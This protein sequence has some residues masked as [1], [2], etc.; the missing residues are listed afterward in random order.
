MNPESRTTI[1]FAGTA[2]GLLLLVLLTGSR[3]READVFTAQGKAFYPDFVD[4]LKATAL[5]VWDF[6]ETTAM[7]KP[8]R[9][10]FEGGRWVI[11]SHSNYPAD[12]KERLA[13]TATA[14]I[15]LK[16]DQIA[17]TTEKDHESLGVVDP[18]DATVTG[19]KGRGRRVKFFAGTTPAADFIFGKDAG[20][21]KKYV[22]MPGDKRT[23]VSKTPGEIS[24]KF[25]D[26]VETD[27]LQAS[28]TAIRRVVIDKYSFDEDAGSIKDRQVNTL[29]REDSSKPWTLSELKDTEEVHTDN[30]SAMTGALDDLKLAGVRPRPGLLAKMK[31]LEELKKANRGQAMMAVQDLASRGFFL[32]RDLSLICNEG[33]MTVSCDDGIVY[34]LRFGEVLYGTGDEVTA[35]G[36]AAPKKE[37]K[38]EEKKD[39]KKPDDKKD[40]KKSGTENR[41]LFVT[42]RFDASLLGAA[43]AEP[44]A[45][46]ADPAKKPEEQKA[47][48]EA[49]KKEKE[50]YE[51]KTKELADKAE[52]GKKRADKLA[53]RLSEWYYV[54]SGESF[55]KLRLD[56]PSLVRPKA[57]PEDKKDDGHK[58]DE[59]DGHKHDEKKPDAVKP[60]EKKPDA[61]KP[62][63]EK[64]SDAPKPPDGAKPVE[65]KKP[66]EAPKA[67]TPKPEEKKP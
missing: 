46:V 13:K 66:A 27:L 60:P 35:G 11:P 39:E 55:K 7:A 5:E 4:P 25:E 47:A 26:W 14:V 20:D 10:A 41:Y 50:D 48:E 16:K 54:I 12:A 9:V 51:R 52:A 62:P 45:Y 23:Y 58:H 38:K 24:A 1:A 63:D 42:V 28:A 30:V 34:Q 59:K 17:S 65:E 67:E 18:Q 8:F 43:P 61:P 40:E 32:T 53:T 56:R 3:A 44:K 15:D 29:A 33:E 64:K 36:P 2:V 22:R 21:G 57:K 6:D 49:A 37:E 31:D 19:S